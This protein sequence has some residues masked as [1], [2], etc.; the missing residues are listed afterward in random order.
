MER[1]NG[2]IIMDGGEIELALKD[3]TDV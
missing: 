1:I 3:L 2:L